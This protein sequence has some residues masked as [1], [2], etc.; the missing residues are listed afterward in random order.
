MCEL[1]RRER[2]SKPHSFV[3]ILA[4]VCVCVCVCVSWHST[5]CLFAEWIST[6]ASIN[7]MYVYFSMCECQVA[8]YGK[9]VALSPPTSNSL[10][11]EPLSAST[12]FDYFSQQLKAALINI[13]IL[14]I[15]QINMCNV[16]GVTCISKLK[17][18]YPSNLP[19]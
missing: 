18:N 13:F 6:A 15:D 11:Q 14:P 10:G 17:Q 9:Q 12:H 16:K 5:L 7:L 19:L 2:V 4:C 1:C 8:C 3:C